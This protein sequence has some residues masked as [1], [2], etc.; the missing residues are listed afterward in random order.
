MRKIRDTTGVIGQLNIFPP[1][2][3]KEFRVHVIALVNGKYYDPIYGKGPYATLND[4][5]NDSL[6]GFRI[7]YD[8]PTQNLIKVL[9]KNDQSAVE[10]KPTVSRKLTLPEIK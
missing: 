2:E 9:R 10:V 4:W 6:E 1:K 5:E 8:S 3:F 7:N